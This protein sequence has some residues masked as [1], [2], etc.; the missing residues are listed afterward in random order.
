MLMVPV[1]QR[2][3]KKDGKFKAIFDYRLSLRPAWITLDEI[4]SLK[5]LLIIVQVL[6]RLQF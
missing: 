6:F 1:F 5:K 4:I 2:Y 3:R